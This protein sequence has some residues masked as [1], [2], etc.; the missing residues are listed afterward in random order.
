[1]EPQGGIQLSLVDMLAQSFLQYQHWVKQSVLCSQTQFRKHSHGYIQW[2]ERLNVSPI[3]DGYTSGHWDMPYVSEQIAIEH[4]VQ[5]A[6][7]WH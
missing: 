3:D 1:M 7:R 6:D 2:Q 5:M 4:A